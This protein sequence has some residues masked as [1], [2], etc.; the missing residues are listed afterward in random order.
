M[1]INILA[2]PDENQVDKTWFKLFKQA[3]FKDKYNIYKIE[4]DY[5]KLRQDFKNHLKNYL[6]NS[7]NIS[8]FS[9]EGFLGPIGSEINEIKLKNLEIFQEIIN[10][11]ENELKIRVIIKFIISIRNQ[12]DMIISSFHYSENF[13][14]SLTLEECLDNILN[15]E[16]YKKIFDY[17]ILVKQIIKIFNRDILILPL[18]LIEQNEKKYIQNIFQFI[19]LDQDL[20]EKI[21]K[22]N[23]NYK[24]YEGEKIYNLRY[25]PKK[26]FIFEI[27]ANVHK[28]LKKNKFYDK[29]FKKS[30]ILKKIYTVISPKYESVLIK[31]KIPEFYSHKI[32]SLYLKNNIELEQLTGVNLKQLGYY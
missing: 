3:H 7:K 32:S 29:N 6:A 2:K 25:S 23:V 10:E 9:D 14:K 11:I 12:Y 4:Y 31:P 24:I 19:G 30:N 16:E 5:N 13:R 8:I 21:N 17:T 27:A 26:S 18:E 15:L 1:N 28:F 22:L 20:K